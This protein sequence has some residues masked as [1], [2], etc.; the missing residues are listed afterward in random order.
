MVDK[1]AETE[2]NARRITGVE[3]R[4]GSAGQPLRIPGRVLVG[5][6]VLIKICRKKPKPRQFFLFNDILVYGTILI[7]KKRFNKQH[8]VPLEDIQLEDVEDEGDLHNGWLIKSRSKS[9]AVYAA[10]PSEKQEWMVH[11]NRCV[12]DLISKG[13]K[14]TEEGLAA[15]WVPDSDARCCMHCKEVRFSLVNRRHHC[16]HCG[17]VVCGA[18]SD[19]KWTLRAISPKPVRVCN[20]CYQALQGRGASGTTITNDIAALP[21]NAANPTP[22]EQS[23][24]WSSDDSDDEAHRSNNAAAGPNPTSFYPK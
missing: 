15:V 6:G 3:E 11:I 16:R 5:E 14:P 7:N 23:D 4:F 1:L 21:S 24:D 17:A 20:L 8:V 22:A 2:A 9:F 10:T 18:C 19:K 13:K 12:A